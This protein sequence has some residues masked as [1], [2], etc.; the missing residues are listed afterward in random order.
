TPIGDEIKHDIYVMAMPA[1]PH[2]YWVKIYMEAMT[3][4]IDTFMVRY[5]HIDE[6]VTDRRIQATP[7]E[8]ELYRNAKNQL[9]ALGEAKQLMQGGKL[10]VINGEGAYREVDQ[11]TLSQSN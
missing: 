3:D 1:N 9:V 2:I 6:V 4:D 8:L 5:N 10:R 11:A 7:K